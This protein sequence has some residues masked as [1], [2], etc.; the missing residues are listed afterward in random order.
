MSVK[1]KKNISRKRSTKNKNN[2]SNYLKYVVVAIIL[3]VLAGIVYNFYPTIK[4]YIN[5]TINPPK[6]IEEIK[7][8]QSKY[9]VF[10]IDVS[11][12]QQDINWDTVFA[13]H[14]IDFIFIRAT[15]GT[16]N[17]DKKFKE[18]WENLQSQ[19]IICGAYHYFRPDENSKKQ[20]EFFIKNVELKEGNLPPVLDIEKISKVQSME[21]LKIALLNWL[22]II[23]D[24]YKVTPIL[25]TY[26][27][28][29]VQWFK[30][31][32]RFDKYLLWLAWYDPSGNPNDINKEWL[33]WQ[34]TDN[35]K[36]KGINNVVDVNIFNGTLKDLDGIRIRN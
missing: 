12:Y 30:D 23:E 5:K 31:D 14:K 27:K 6:D 24:Y 2:N 1:T 35:G 34:F 22:R 10:G 17:I 19:N 32:S 28:Y 16:N 4:S 20:A 26:N 3:I 25:Y 7:S 18:N 21:S 8:E 15:A 11:V 33:F 36:I 13:N 9:S 29:Y